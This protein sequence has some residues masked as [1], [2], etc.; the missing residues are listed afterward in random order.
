M[1][2][3]MRQVLPRA[4]R[5][6]NRT[7]QRIPRAWHLFNA[8][9]KVVGRVAAAA[10]HLL[11]GKHK[12]VFNRSKDCGDYVVIVNAEFV[13]FT[14]KKWK[15]KIYRHHTGYPGGL[16][17][18]AA[19]VMRD[20]K[21]ERIL[22]R[23]IKGMLSNNPMMR[24]KQMSRLRVFPTDLHK[25]ENQ[26]AQIPQSEHHV[27]NFLSPRKVETVEVYWE[28]FP[29]YDELLYKNNEP[30]PQHGWIQADLEEDVYEVDE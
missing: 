7:H 11:Q 14:G 5:R 12:P 10:A 23:A 4:V 17:E 30:M 26:I 15:K 28:K 9:G 13:N 6:S 1:S 21:P 2:S 8:D 20:R 24:K 3:R 19:K 29:D 16:K 22:E 18:I 27:D 25:H